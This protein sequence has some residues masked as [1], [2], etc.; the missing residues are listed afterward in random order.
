MDTQYQF[1]A[2]IVLVVWL[3]HMSERSEGLSSQALECVARHA[4]ITAD[5]HV[6][7]R[8]VVEYSC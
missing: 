6:E 1:I 3:R 7:V 5:E 8:D 2:A 4:E